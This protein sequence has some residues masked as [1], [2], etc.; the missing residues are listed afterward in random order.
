MGVARKSRVCRE[1]FTYSNDRKHATLKSAALT[2]LS[3]QRS[4]F[5]RAF[6][7]LWKEKQ[8]AY[9]RVRFEVRV[10]QSQSQRC[11]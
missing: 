1:V 5:E 4:A 10:D 11:F 8:E 7:G 2:C 9:P 6:L 3:V